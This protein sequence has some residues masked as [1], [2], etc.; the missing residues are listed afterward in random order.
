MIKKAIIFSLVFLS[1]NAVSYTQVRKYSNEFLSIGIGARSLGMANSVVASEKEVTAGYWN[2]TGLLHLDHDLQLGAMHA[3]YFAGIA[4]YDY[5]AVGFSLS[6]VS[7][8][9]VSVIRFGVDDIPNTLEL[10]DSDGNIRYDRIKSFSAADYAFLF[11]Y[12]REHPKE[13]LSYGGN[14]KIIHRIAG[15]FASAWGFGLDAAARF[16]YKNWIFSGIARD[17]TSTFNAWKFNTGELEEVFLL[18]GNEIPSNSLEI[19]VP[20]LILATAYNYQISNKFGL[21]AEVDFDCTFDGKR[22]VVIKG[23]FMSVDPHLGLEFDYNKLVYFRMG[24][25]NFQEIPGFDNSK[26]LSFQPN[27]GLGIRYK[28]LALD[29]ALT[30]IGDNSIALYSNVFTLMWAI[31]KEENL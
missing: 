21:L 16:Y 5:G 28:K 31:D 20:K 17:V 9:G 6:D 10:I 25:G 23:D 15:E 14:V 3:E 11:S 12:A 7:A 24:I 8:F 27:L 19:T 26:E 2:P 1:F 18:T 4:K 30:D 22:N 29:Y 13:G